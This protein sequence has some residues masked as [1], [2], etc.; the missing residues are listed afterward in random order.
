MLSEEEKKEYI[1]H[2][3]LDRLYCLGENDFDKSKVDDS[4]IKAVLN[5]CKEA[6]NLIE[7]QSKE[8]E[9]Y[10][11]Q[12]DLEYSEK[13]I[14]EAYIE[15]TNVAHELCNKKWENK[16]KAKIEEIQEYIQHSANPLSIDNSKFA[17]KVLQSLLEK[18]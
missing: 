5:A 4:Y 12:L 15:G 14:K 17:I 11:K 3:I 13:L 9:E 16:I 7:K 10:E 2:E 6:K 18:E 1:E 8:I